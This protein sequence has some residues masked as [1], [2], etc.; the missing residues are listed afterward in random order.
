MRITRITQRLFGQQQQNDRQSGVTVD[1]CN[2]TDLSGLNRKQLLSLAR[3]YNWVHSIDLGNG[4]ITPGLWGRG[5]P[6]ITLAFD[7][8]D[9]R[10]KKVLDI[11]CWDGQ[12]TFEAEDRGAREVV[13]TDLISQRDFTEQPTFEVAAM[14]RGSAAKYRPNM[15][16][17]EAESIGGKFDIILYMGIIYHL[18]D[19]LMSLAI[20]RRMLEVGGEVLFESAVLE[21]QGCFANFYYRNQFCGDQTNWWVPTRDCMRQWIEC[22]FFKVRWEGA[23]WGHGDNQRHCMVAEAIQHRDPLYARPPERLEEFW[24]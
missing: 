13:A 15:S 4:E 5:N 12:W 17:Y 10:G 18:K 19:P 3:S 6:Q 1:V 11:G 2:R 14:L 23:P 22:S 24:R 8:I 16:V 20:L 21:Q 9:F 7:A